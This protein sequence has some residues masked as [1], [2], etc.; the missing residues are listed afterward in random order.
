MFGPIADSWFRFE[1]QSRGS[2]H[3][4]LLL[5]VEKPAETGNDSSHSDTDDDNGIDRCV[6]S[7]YNHVSAHH[8]F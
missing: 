6:L 2:L 8:N 4:H 7:Y 1:E 5:W 3:L